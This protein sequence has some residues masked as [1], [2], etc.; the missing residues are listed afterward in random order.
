M[1]L[2]E[3]S[4]YRSVNIEA[5][6]LSPQESFRDC[7]SSDVVTWHDLVE[8]LPSRW[9]GSHPLDTP[10]VMPH[11]EPNRMN[12][13]GP[14]MPKSYT[15]RPPLRPSGGEHVFTDDQ[16]HLRSAALDRA[17]SRVAPSCFAA[18]A[19][20]ANLCAPWPWIR[21]LLAIPST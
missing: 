13:V 10:L 7:L 9:V 1:A 17:T 2:V 21:S 3:V 11:S 19:T 6:P 20:S 12:E 4:V 18:S 16:G 15:R 14:S 8:S 5:H